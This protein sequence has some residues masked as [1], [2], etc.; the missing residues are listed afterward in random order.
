M[1]SNLSDGQSV[2]RT[3]LVVDDFDDT[4]LLLRTWLEKR[5]FR[6]VEAEDGVKAIA[7]AQ[8]VR[9][10][11]IIMDVEMPEL[12]GLSAT[13]KIKSIKELSDVPVVAVSAY[14]AEQFRSEALAAGCREYV[15]TPF[16]PVD[17]ERLI[18]SLL[19][20]L[21]LVLLIPFG[22]RAQN[23]C[24]TKIAELP[25]SA[26]LRGFRL[27]MTME[28]VKARVP[29]VVFGPTDPLG[30][31]KTTINPYFDPRIDKAGFADIRSVSLDFV[32]G[33]LVSLWIGYEETFKWTS[34]EDYVTGIS[35]ALSVPA[36]WAAW[37]GR[38]QQLRC[39][40]FE[41][42]VSMV[43]RGPSF[44]IFDLAADETLTARRTAAEE[45]K[46][47]TVEEESTESEE[48]VGDKKNK[49]YYPANCQPATE[50]TG[51]NRVVFETVESAEKAGYKRANNCP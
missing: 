4:R 24:R 37:K 22:V 13:R 30:T 18:R 19:F 9:P 46:E 29:Q 11:L 38:G 21:I 5:G 3:I 1:E 33:R 31:S 2:K 45:A 17:L 35:K 6:V 25:E 8:E 43:A 27:G 14:G 10:D 20:A 26:E 23:G 32:D 49:I 40:D 34:V 44:R 15:S 48:I 36:G 12:D 50:I 28:Q 39:G 51:T 42:T 16:E 7:T 47:A 41:M